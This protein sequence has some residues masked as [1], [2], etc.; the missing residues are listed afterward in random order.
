MMFI[1]SDDVAEKIRV[2][3]YMISLSENGEKFLWW[4]LFL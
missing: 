2:P 1:L 3:G 4:V